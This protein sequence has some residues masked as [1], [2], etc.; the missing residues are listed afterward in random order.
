MIDPF[1]SHSYYRGIEK[2]ATLRKIQH[3]IME[4][5]DNVVMTGLIYNDTKEWE[6]KEILNKITIVEFPKIEKPIMQPCD[7]DIVLDT[8]KINVVCT[9]SK[10]ET[11]RN[12]E[13]TLK[14]CER[15]K[16][17]NVLFHFIGHG[18]CETEREVRGNCIFYKARSHQAIRNLQLNA[19]FLLNIGNVVINQLPSK[20]LEYIST[21]KPIVN[22]FKTE[23]CP[24]LLLMQSY[25]ALNVFEEDEIESAVSGIKEFISAEHIEMDF[26]EI[27]QRYE[28]YAPSYAVKKWLTL[29]KG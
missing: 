5:C 3:E 4:Q 10:N 11:V 23:K 20:V 7:D 21:G 16:D 22:V 1:E 12:S 26:E 13:Y 29:I 17:E 25:D 18:W 19:D 2:V 9:G 8:T 15:L 24:T 14:L 28:I 6:T 27:K